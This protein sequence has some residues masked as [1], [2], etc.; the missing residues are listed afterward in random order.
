[1]LRILQICFLAVLMT[2]PARVLYADDSTD[3]VAKV[4]SHKTLKADFIQQVFDQR[5]RM[6]QTMRGRLVLQR[7]GRFRWT[8]QSPYEQEIVADGK[9]VWMYDVD[10]EQVTVKQQ[11]QTVGG[12]PA[13]LL[14]SRDEWREQFDVSADGSKYGLQWFKLTPKQEDGSFE[15]LRIGV[16]GDK[17][18][19]LEIQDSFGQLTTVQFL[20]LQVDVALEPEVFVF[21]LPEDADV[22]DETMFQ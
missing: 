11:D 18:Q 1:M 14:S 7:P 22:I 16:E 4:F 8:Y 17:L 3:L 10:L 21:V 5:Q 12:T 9:K 20:N 6:Q 19:R 13:V 15:Y 2:L